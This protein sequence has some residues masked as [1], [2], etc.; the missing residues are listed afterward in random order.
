MR[1]DASP[2]HTR[3]IW[4]Q[5]V[6]YPRRFL[7][8][9]GRTRLSPTLTWRWFQMP[10]RKGV[11]AVCLARRCTSVRLLKLHDRLGDELL[12]GGH[13]WPCALLRVTCREA[14]LHVVPKRLPR[15]VG[16]V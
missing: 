12:S 14:R 16:K 9:V 11:K 3:V 2:D 6:S 10:S 1:F 4:P 5:R 7:G 8:R 15:E 13:S